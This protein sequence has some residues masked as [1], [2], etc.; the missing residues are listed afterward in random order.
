M[1]I[2]TVANQKGGVGKTTI[3]FNLAI[4]TQAAIVID[5]D[6]MRLLTKI[7]LVRDVKALPLLPIEKEANKE[8]LIK[9]AQEFSDGSKVVVIDTQGF[10]SDLVRYAVGV[11]DLVLIPCDD[12]ALELWGTREF[13]KVIDEIQTK[14]KRKILIRGVFNKLNP[15][16]KNISESA[17]LLERGGLRMLNSRV[18]SRGALKAATAEGKAACEFAPAFASKDEFAALADEILNTIKEFTNGES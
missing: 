13:L 9:L 14:L 3:A 16:T 17:T 5:L 12:S 1:P 2:I 7:N 15:S 6:P 10:D 11:A 18:R 4:A 8:R